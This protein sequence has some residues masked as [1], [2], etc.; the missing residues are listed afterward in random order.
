MFAD[1]NQIETR[2]KNINLIT[3]TLIKYDLANVSELMAANI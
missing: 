1:G 3:E 2:T